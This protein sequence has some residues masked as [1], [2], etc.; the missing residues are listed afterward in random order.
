MILFN[1][2]GGVSPTSLNSFKK[3]TNKTMWGYDECFIAL[4]AAS[5][6]VTIDIGKPDGL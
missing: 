2:G 5:L 6:P 4:S 1:S 3:T